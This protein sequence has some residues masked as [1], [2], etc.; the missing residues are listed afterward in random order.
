[1]LSKNL[2]FIIK[3]VFLTRTELKIEG[4]W[5]KT[6]LLWFNYINEFMQ[7]IVAEGVFQEEKNQF[8]YFSISTIRLSSAN[9]SG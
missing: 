9:L 5:S 2:S 8:K 7:H 4:K 6:V 3:R 1:M